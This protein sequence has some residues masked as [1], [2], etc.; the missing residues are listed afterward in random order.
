MAL[1]RDA[2]VRRDFPVG[3]R[4]YD[5]SAVDAHLERIAADVEELRRAAEAPPSRPGV[6]GAA[7]EQVRAI[8]AAA[9][10]S[11]AGIEQTAREEAAATRARADEESRAEV[12]RVRDVVGGLL[13]RL[14]AVEGELAAI[15]DGI[16]ELR[17][18]EAEPEPETAAA[19]EPQP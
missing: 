12:A 1:D 15:E 19:V 11:A 10:E 16:G 5:H 7:G 13:D 3:R 17:P 18:V 9:E 4:G 6:A 2:I 8:V 14:R